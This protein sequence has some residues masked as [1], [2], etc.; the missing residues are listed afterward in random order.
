MSQQDS[1]VGVVT[2][3]A[4]TGKTYAL[5]ERIKVDVVAGRDPARVVATT[6]TIKAAD[7]LRERARGRL[8]SLGDAPNAVRML[9]ARVGTVNG[10]CGGLVKEFA[11]GLGL[12]PIVE[13]IDE[14][15]AKAAFRKSSD[16]AV[17]AHADELDRLASLLGGE[18]WI[19]DV[20]RVVELARANNIPESDFTRCADRSMIGF[21]K[22]AEAP[23]PGET[24][25]SLD[26]NV[27]A[28]A[29]DVLREFNGVSGLVGL[30]VTAL[31]DVE[32]FLEVGIDRQPWQKWAKLSKL[33]PAVKDEPKF[34]GLKAAAS[35]FAR[36]P[37][38]IA[39]V[40]AYVSGVFSCAAA[41]MQA[42]EQHKR[43]W[44]LVDFVDQ[45]RLALELLGKP[46]LEQQLRERLQTVF[47]DEF[48]DTN[49]LQLAVFV[50]MSRL[51]GSSVWVGDP[52]QSIYRFR[53]TDPDLITYVA[54]DIRK[55]TGG[56][57]LTLDRNWR[58]R[59]SLVAFFND[60]F[61]PTFQSHGLPPGAT[62]IA[63]VERKD[64]PG[65]QTPL[66]VWRM[67]QEK[68]S[69]TYVGALAA[70]VLDA[71]A[72]ACDWKV[73]DGKESRP[74]APGDVAI[75]CRSNPACLSIADILARSGIKVAIKRDGL[76]GTLECRLGL[77]AL[78]WTT[79]NRDGVAL[80]EMAHLFGNSEGQPAWFEASLEEDGRERLEAM[81]PI[82]PSLRNVGEGSRHK[83]PLEFLDAIL[84]SGG[85]SQAVLRWGDVD[86][87]LLNLE[88]LRGMVA[89]YEAE[90]SR[91]RA[92]A[93]VSDLC[94]WLTNQE[95]ERPASQAKDAVTVLTYHRSKGLE[96][97][98][99]IL[100]DLDSEPKGDAFGVQVASDVPTSAIDWRDPLAGRWIRFWPWPFHKQS[101]EVSLDTAAANSI[102]GQ[103][104][105]RSERAERARLLYV[106]AT[107]ARDYLVLTAKK[108]VTKKAERI[109]SEWLDELVADTGG[110]VLSVP[111]ADALTVSVNG[112]AHHVRV[113][114][115]RSSDDGVAAAPAGAFDGSVVPKVSYP[116]LRLRP[117]D[118]ERDDEA[119]LGDEFDLGWRLPFAGATDMTSV[120]EA[121]HRF[122]AA[123]DPSRDDAWRVALAARLLDAW[124][125]SCLDPR[126]VV[127]MGTRFL[128]FIDK[129]W[130]QA[131]L[132]R[133]APILYRVGDRTMSGR[134]DLVIEAPDEIVI[135]DH[136]TFPG[137]RAQRLEQARK[138][139]G[140]LRLYR[141]A[142]RAAVGA[143]PVKTALHLPIAG[144]VFMVE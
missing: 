97:P 117:S 32:G 43:A 142:I 3:S 12:S 42:Y 104:A 88:A 39:Q 139:A 105:A 103:E 28:E 129:R 137:G 133:E 37:R 61:A 122:L 93:T 68:D 11:F 131:V 34:Q 4:G 18:E 53:Q 9:G 108:V 91:E 114:E 109:E 141:D 55:A 92:P 107:R 112:V 116:A 130:P 144:E 46:E 27:V 119:V 17:S 121:V 136:K 74:L 115:F 29:K 54:Q 22:L 140:Q 41:A 132:R 56:A 76:F 66:N 26:A 134:L 77:A 125:V 38:L 52:K 14:D 45:E 120:G 7:E 90:C 1:P 59:P 95:A 82:A 57:D 25:A 23:L 87:R 113:S 81:V 21:R 24:E 48:Q 5:T 60:A 80:A 89:D 83:T 98:L 70:G 127:E 123:D 62:R 102:E 20:V 118:A 63:H 58:S 106:G 84:G 138:Y 143:K 8:L 75:L 13:V 72:N 16:V 47:V 101:K 2:A 69:S 124:G 31:K 111:V 126:H 100:T 51:A 78:R 6:F 86:D 19:S 85:V 44:G 50:A 36:H 135:I 40:G 128:A 15:G 94:V 73:A 10:V 71:L 30:T 79:D 99:V 49:P 96:W 110:P 33:K 64:A 35:A 67:V 65:Q